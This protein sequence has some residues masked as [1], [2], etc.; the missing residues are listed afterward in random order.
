M[1]DVNKTVTFHSHSVFQMFL[2][3]LMC[4]TNNGAIIIR[5]G[6]NSE[7]MKWVLLETNSL[8]NNLKRTG[9]TQ[10]ALNFF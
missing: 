2:D 9:Y 6:H 1:E 4:Q 10:H 3:S 8:L 5:V 7:S